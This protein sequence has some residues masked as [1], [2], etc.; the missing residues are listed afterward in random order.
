[1]LV[2]NYSSESTKILQT[3]STWSCATADARHLVF[4]VA[5]S[6]SGTFK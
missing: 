5:H 6:L 2:I 4:Q 3:E 1:M